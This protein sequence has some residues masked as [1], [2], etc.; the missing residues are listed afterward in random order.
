MDTKNTSGAPYAGHPSTSVPTLAIAMRAAMTKLNRLLHH[1]RSSN[2]VAKRAHASPLAT[3]IAN[4]IHCMLR[5]AHMHTN[6][7]SRAGMH[8]RV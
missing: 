5:N 8:A 6:S 3:A 1:P 7:T 2:D 4:C